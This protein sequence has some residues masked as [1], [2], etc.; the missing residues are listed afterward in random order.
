MTNNA[1]TMTKKACKLER[2]DMPGLVRLRCQGCGFYAAIDVSGLSDKGR[3]KLVREHAQSHE[4]HEAVQPGELD[5]TM[6]EYFSGRMRKE[7][8]ATMASGNHNELTAEEKQERRRARWR[9]YYHSHKEQYKEWGKRWRE[10]RAAAAA[11]RKPEPEP[12]KPKSS[13][14]A[15]P[16]RDERGRY[17]KA[18]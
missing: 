12:T 13:S 5:P 1:T 8:G 4:Q 7:G 16:P 9:E 14:K 15:S 6:E 3:E 11:S 17:I 2:S 10:R 18:S